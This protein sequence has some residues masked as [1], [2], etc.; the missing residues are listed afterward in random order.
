MSENHTS[1]FLSFF[2]CSCFKWKGKFSPCD[3]VSFR[4]E[5]PTA[6]CIK[7]GK[8]PG[9]SLHTK[10]RSFLRVLVS[11]KEDQRG[12]SSSQY[13][14]L[15]HAITVPH[16]CHLF[17]QSWFRITSL[18]GLFFGSLIHWFIHPPFH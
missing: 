12:I 3:S 11:E 4:T 18:E 13:K 14:L 6:S 16:K 8:F 2:F 15:F 5:V 7:A 1:S 9:Q 10:Q 17:S